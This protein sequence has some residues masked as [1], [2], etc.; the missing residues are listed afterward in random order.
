MLTAHVGNVVTNFDAVPELFKGRGRSIPVLKQI[1]SDFT[2]RVALN[3]ANATLYIDCTLTGTTGSVEISVSVWS[4]EG[5]EPTPI[6]SWTWSATD[7]TTIRLP[8]CKVLEVTTRNQANM[9]VNATVH[10]QEYAA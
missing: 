3:R 9:L 7:S 6:D 2:N 1:A 4:Q 10:E 5:T 8:E